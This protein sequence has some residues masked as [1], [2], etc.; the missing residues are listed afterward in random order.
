MM[1]AERWKSDRC[2]TDG[3]GPPDRPN[4]EDRGMLVK[5]FGECWQTG[6]RRVLVV[7][8]DSEVGRGRR[9]WCGMRGLEDFSLVAWKE[10]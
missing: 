7:T 3:N 10:C 9:R 5:V 1:K 8:L 6:N 2:N 4:G